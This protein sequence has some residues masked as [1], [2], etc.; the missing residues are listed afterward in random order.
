MNDERTS[1]AMHIHRMHRLTLPRVNP[2]FEQK[3][4]WVIEQDAMRGK[5]NSKLTLDEDKDV[6]FVKAFCLEHGFKVDIVAVSM[7]SRNIT[8]HFID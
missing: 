2:T 3:L 1:F 5:R 4:K 7:R 6:E 8:I